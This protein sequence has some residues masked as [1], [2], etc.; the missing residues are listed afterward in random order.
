MKW[1]CHYCSLNCLTKA[2]LHLCDRVCVKEGV[3]VP[4]MDK[5][6]YSEYV[7]SLKGQLLLFQ[8]THHLNGTCLIHNSTFYTFIL[9]ITW[10]TVVF[11]GWHLW[12]THNFLGWHLW[13]THHFL[14][15]HLW[16]THHFLG[17]HV[18]STHHFLGWHVWSARHFFYYF[19]CRN[20][21]VTFLNQ[22][23]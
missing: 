18:W 20:P 11:L 8:E 12:S 3:S 4:K 16:S 10:N 7:N 23:L 19:C 21:Q 17:W 2:E 14:G 22:T 6:Y 9:S 1:T 15:W 13:S 5:Y